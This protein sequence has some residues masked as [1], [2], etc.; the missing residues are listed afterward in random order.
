VL[1][2]PEAAARVDGQDQLEVIGAM[3]QRPTGVT[4]LA[5]LAFIRGVI[6]ILFGGLGALLGG[7]FAGFLSPALGG[8]AVVWGLV[9][10]VLGAAFVYIGWGFWRLVPA[11]WRFGIFVA[12]ADILVTI[13][14]ALFG[15]GGINTGTIIGIA[16]SLII[17][18]YLLTPA[19]KAAFG[20]TGD[21]Q[22]ELMSGV[23]R[24]GAA[25]AAAPPA[26]ATPPPAEPPAAPPPAEPPAAPPPA[27]SWSGDTGGD[28]APSAG[29]DDTDQ[30]A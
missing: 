27:S 25:A 7:V 22:T 26:A 12:A 8:L 16:I 2:H 18:Y 20:I 24:G 21:L 17:I 1:Q 6:L 15:G 3:N 13:L 9:M 19:V 23:S 5:I 11:S 28:S 14:I 29:G 30:N 4:I 10:L